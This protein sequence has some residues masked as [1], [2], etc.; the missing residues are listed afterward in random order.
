M[1]QQQI[2]L[3]IF[4]LASIAGMAF[5]PIFRSWWR[6]VRHFPFESLLFF[7]LFF[8][9]FFLTEETGFQRQEGILNDPLRFTRI[10]VYTLITALAWFAILF[11][12]KR[13][14]HVNTSVWIM[15]VFAAVAMLTALYSLDPLFT[16]WK[17]FEIVTHV[18]VAILL[19]RRANSSADLQEIYGIAWLALTFLLCIILWGG[20]LYPEEAFKPFVWDR[21][22]RPL[23]DQPFSSGLQGIFPVV[24]LNSVTQIAAILTLVAVSYFMV[25]SGDRERHWPMIILLVA[26]VFGMLLGHSRTSLFAV[27]LAFA[28]L[29]LFSESK[30]PKLV[31]AAAVLALA[32]SASTLDIVKNF[33]LRGQTEE[34]LVGLSGR[35]SAWQEFA[36]PLIMDRPFFGYGYYAGLRTLFNAIGVDNAYLNVLM[37]GGLILLTIFLIPVLIVMYQVLISRPSR[38]HPLT[39]QQ[40]LLWFQTSGLFILLFVRS[41]TGPS[42][43]GN[44]FNLIL[45]LICSI[46]AA[47][48]YRQR[49]AAVLPETDMSPQSK[50]RFF[51]VGLKPL[52]TQRTIPANGG[53]VPIRP[54]VHSRS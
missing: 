44:H 26:A 25:F 41:T 13:E 17:G 19:A 2:T 48:S 46:G 33:V 6:G 51:I 37:G 22:G 49:Y 45:F 36:L 29:S 53:A 1:N 9:L 3:L 8:G 32:V 15:L 54:H 34:V 14:A 16:L 50:P 12:R 10:I 35:T 20:L 11:G 43:E 38:W 21:F 5:F 28:I 24:A 7:T 30:I 40:R 23:S 27:I 31:A 52:P 18:S 4:S 47:V 42:F 39:P